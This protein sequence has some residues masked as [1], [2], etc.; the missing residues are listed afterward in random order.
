MCHIFAPP[1]Y[2]ELV[3]IVHRSDAK[4]AVSVQGFD[5]SFPKSLESFGITREQYESFIEA[6]MC[7]ISSQCR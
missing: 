3:P 7:I 4:D 5:R 2:P 1:F 6:G